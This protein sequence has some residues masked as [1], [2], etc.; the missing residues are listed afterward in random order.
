MKTKD[1]KLCD[2]RISN[3]LLPE[4]FPK[5]LKKI[6]IMLENLK[7]VEGFHSYFSK[8]SLKKI[9]IANLSGIGKTPSRAYLAECVPFNF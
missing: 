1:V 6:E 9:L 4:N 7:A 5:P 2:K 8:I 3:C